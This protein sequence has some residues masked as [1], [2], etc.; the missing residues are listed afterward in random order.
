MRYDADVGPANDRKRRFRQAFADRLAHLAATRGIVG[1][2]AVGEVVGKGKATAYGWTSGHNLP[3]VD[4]LMDLAEALGYTVVDF[5]AFEDAG[6][7]QRLARFLARL[8]NAATDRKETTLRLLDELGTLLDG[9]A[10]DA[11]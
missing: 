6:V 11:D 7:D 3:N 2:K 8:A 5:F 10:Q 4:V 9:T 1:P